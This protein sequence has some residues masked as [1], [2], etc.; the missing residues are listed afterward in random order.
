MTT[1]PMPLSSLVQP[2][3]RDKS[4]LSKVA[5]L[6]SLC[7]VVLFEYLAGQP[8]TH[9]S[10]DINVQQSSW[11]LSLCITAYIAPASPHPTLSLHLSS[12]PPLPASPHSS[13]PSMLLLP[14][15][16]VQYSEIEPYSEKKSEP[17]KPPA[18]GRQHQN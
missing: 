3:Q 4:L 1:K 5:P 10:G 7:L 8:R 2:E 13:K 15:V 18:D 14:Q 9:L 11:P 17:T 12:F 6:V 16:G